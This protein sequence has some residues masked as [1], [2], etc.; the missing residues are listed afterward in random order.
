[1]HIKEEVLEND[2]FFKIE[3]DP[4]NQLTLIE[5]EQ[6]DSFNKSLNITIPYINFRRNIVT[7]GILLNKLLGKSILIGQVKIKIHKLCEP[8]KHLQDYLK[9]NDLVKNLVHKGGF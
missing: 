9:Q 6:I 1:M 2:R 5:K 7:E 4:N 3:N 8:C